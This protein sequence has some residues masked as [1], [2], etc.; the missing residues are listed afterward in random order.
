MGNSLTE[1]IHVVQ[2]FRQGFVESKY[3][4]FVHWERKDGGHVKPSHTVV[5]LLEQGV[6]KTPETSLKLVI[7]EQY[8]CPVVYV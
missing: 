1:V 5:D 3:R 2:V 8:W 4:P 7:G 6:G